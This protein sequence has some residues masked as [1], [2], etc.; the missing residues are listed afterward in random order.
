MTDK[1]I[2]EKQLLEAIITQR[3][4]AFDILS[5]MANHVFN[6]K[7]AAVMG[8]AQTIIKDTQ[9]EQT[10]EDAKCIIECA[11]GNT[12]YLQTLGRLFLHA[13]KTSDKDP[14]TEFDLVSL[15]DDVSV[16]FF[17]DTFRGMVEM[18]VEGN[19]FEPDKFYDFMIYTDKK[20]LCQAFIDIIKNSSEAYNGGI[21]I[22][23]PLSID[24]E[25]VG[26]QSTLI[27]IADKGCGISQEV[28]PH[29]F[30][31]GY[32]HGKEHLAQ[33]H[34]YGL[35]VAQY[36]I[37]QCSGSLDVQSEGT[38]KGTIVSVRLPLLNIK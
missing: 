29:I 14:N 12:R 9:E 11:S 10:K 34:G 19:I 2:T 15:I 6:N 24:I 16:F 27:R 37:G 18:K 5:D 32:S 20:R 23:S 33:C 21:T 13:F 3:M 4:H 1:I 30:E 26:E 7:N 8:Y 35:N 36:I 17:P 22:S 25:R 28:M 31:L 38:G